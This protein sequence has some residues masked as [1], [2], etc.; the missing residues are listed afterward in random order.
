MLGEIES[1]GLTIANLLLFIDQEWKSLGRERILKLAHHAKLSPY[2]NALVREANALKYIL[3]EA[4]ERV[5]NE[6]SRPLASFVKIFDELTNAFSF[7]MKVDGVTKTLTEEEIRAYRTNPDRTIRKAST[8][9]IRAVYGTA[10]HQIVLGNVYAGIVKSCSADVNLRGYTSVM[11]PQNIAEELDNDV[12]KMLINQVRAAYPLYARFLR[13]KRKKLGFKKLHVWDTSAPFTK[14]E[15]TYSFETAVSMLLETYRAFDPEFE[16]YAKEMLDDGR[17]DV[18]PKQGKTKGAFASYRHGDKSFILLNHTNKLRDVATLAHEMGHAI[19]G[20]YSQKQKSAVYGSSLCLAETASIFSEMLLGEQ[21]LKTLNESEKTEY[22]NERIQDAFATI[23]RQIQY[24]LFE[25][26]VHE[27]IHDGKELTYKEFNALW[28]EEQVALSGNEITYDIPAEKESAWSVIPHIFH[29]PFYCY[30][31]SF[32]NTLVYALWNR[33]QK[34]GN[35]FNTTFKNILS[36]GGSLP[37][38]ELL[39]QYGIDITS[40]SFYTNAISEIE[41]MIALLEKLPAVK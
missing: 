25:K 36:A 7:R 12:V 6:A 41:K 35:K 11:E 29:T 18:F 1:I 39:G 4:E 32:G 15:K 22:Y 34:E 26:R 33:Y 27:A 8:Q 3:T 17:V 9:A 20:Y 2:K 40:S 21:I 13:I 5:I 16:A 10:Y 30:A 37:P 19:H 28:R 38:R 31:Y 14:I 24:I 23:F